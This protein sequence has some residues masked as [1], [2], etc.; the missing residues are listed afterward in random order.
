MKEYTA[1]Q[2]EQGNKRQQ[3]AA[4]W[5]S[6]D[7]KGRVYGAQPTSINDVF[8]A[9]KPKAVKTVTIHMYRTSSGT[10]KIGYERLASADWVWDYL[11]S[12]S[13]TLTEGEFAE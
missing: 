8:M 13:V 10:L 5:L 12:K 9:P 2:I 7:T 11:G 4:N 6:T 3:T 1:E